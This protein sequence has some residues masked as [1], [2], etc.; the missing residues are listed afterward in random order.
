MVEYVA[1]ISIIIL[2]LTFTVY[3]RIHLLLVAPE[4]TIIES[5][6]ERIVVNIISS[7]ALM[8]IKLILIWSGADSFCNGSLITSIFTTYNSWLEI[9]ESIQSDI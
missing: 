6:L 5:S 8:G 7:N 2:L 9:F 1:L 3:I 4:R